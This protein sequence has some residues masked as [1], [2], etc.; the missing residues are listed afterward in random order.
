M[1]FNRILI[2]A[3]AMACV[4]TFYA[5]ARLL[6]KLTNKVKQLTQKEQSSKEPTA[7][8]AYDA[9]QQGEESVLHTTDLS[10]IDPKVK[11]QIEKFI[12]ADM[13]DLLKEFDMQQV[14]INDPQ[15]E[16]SQYDDKFGKSELKDNFLE[17][18]AKKRYICRNCYRN[19]II[20]IGNAIHIR[21]MADR[22][23]HQ[24]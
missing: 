1:K 16:W 21:R 6:E 19:T 18:E 23:R 13:M 3:T 11:A 20:L 10:S 12:G 9:E 8:M 15:Y 14:G 22:S 4:S 17:L 7:D 5:D 2:V 24:R